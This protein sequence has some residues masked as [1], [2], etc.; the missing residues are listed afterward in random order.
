M[1]CCCIGTCS[2][3]YP[4]TADHLPATFNALRRTVP[5]LRVQ[6]HP[7]Q[8]VQLAVPVRLRAED[9]ER[10]VNGPIDG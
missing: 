7:Q 9:G 1:L 2:G 4:G 10:L 8:L 3:R 6:G 5:Q